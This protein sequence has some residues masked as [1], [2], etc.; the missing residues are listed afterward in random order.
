MRYTKL[1]STGIDISVICVGCMGFADGSRGGKHPWAV[2][3]ATSRELIKAA[4]DA[5][6]NFFDTANM[7]SEGTSEEYVGR[8]LRDMADRD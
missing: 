4:L 1:G 3:E 8:A 6:I 2:D 7:Y 5:G